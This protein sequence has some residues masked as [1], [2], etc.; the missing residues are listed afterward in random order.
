MVIIACLY[1]AFLPVNQKPAYIYYTVVSY[2]LYSI[3]SNRLIPIYHRRGI[4]ALKRGR[5]EQAISLF[6][7][8]HSFFSRHTWLDR[9]RSL[10]MLS[11]S[12]FSYRE[13]ALFNIAVCQS[14]QGRRDQAIQ[15][16]GKIMIEFPGSRL[17]QDF[18]ETASASNDSNFS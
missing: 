15:T 1:Y 6:E 2:L 11:A 8:S 3:T 17:G 16:I 5:Y 18:A 9:Y 12:E 13:L 14:Q 7:S 4:Q 10:T